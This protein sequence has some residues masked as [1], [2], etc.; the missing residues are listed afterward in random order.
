MIKNIF[1]SSAA[2]M[3]LG[4]AVAPAQAAPIVFKGDGLNAVPL[5]NV[6]QDCGTVGSDFCTTDPTLGFNY[7]VS[8]IA[9]NATGLAN[10]V[11][12][13]LIQDVFPANS[14]IAAL[15][16]VDP[17]RDQTEFD[18]G[19]SIR[20]TFENEVQL[21]NIEFNSGA[22]Q[23][24]STPGNEGPCGFFNLIIDGAMEGTFEAVDLLTTVFVGQV[25]EFVAATSGA[26]FVIAQFDVENVTEVPLPGSLPLLVSGLAGLAFARR[27][28]K[29][30]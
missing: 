6:S 2:A 5:S 11:A 14:G 12:T 21:T 20:F 16:E 17:T 9:F 7:D 3:L 29:S 26:G 30:P 28:R 23:D 4:F 18:S 13:R 19:E 15:S 22:D 10:G 1:I 24:C 8:G 27:T 25:F